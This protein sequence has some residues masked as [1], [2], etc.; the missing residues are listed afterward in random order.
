[1]PLS[2]SQFLFGLVPF[3]SELRDLSRMAV[4]CINS[5][6]AVS[7]GKPFDGVYGERSRTAQGKLHDAVAEA[8]APRP[9][10]AAVGFVPGRAFLILPAPASRP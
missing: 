8:A 10:V 2:G 6:C 9:L 1:M 4:S 5:V 7:V 3:R